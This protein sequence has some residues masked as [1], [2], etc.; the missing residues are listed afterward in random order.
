MNFEHYNRVVASIY[1]A[2]TD[3]AHW[4][5]ALKDVSHYFS[6]QGAG[7]FIQN[8]QVNYV[9]PLSFLGLNDG[10]LA[11][12]SDYYGDINPTFAEYEELRAGTMFTEQVF[13]Q[14][15]Q[16]S[17]YYNNT[18]FY[19]EW[20][21]PQG[22]AHAA[23]GML[24]VENNEMLHFTLL[25]SAEQG[26]YSQ[27][28]LTLL[29][30]FSQHILS[31]VKYSKVFEQLNYRMM[32]A[33]HMLGCLGQ[34]LV[35]LGQDLQVLDLNQAAANQIENNLLLCIRKGKLRSTNM[36]FNKQLAKQSQQIIT[37]GSLNIEIPI[38]LDLPTYQQLLLLLMPAPPTVQTYF[39]RPVIILIIQDNQ[40]SE[41]LNMHYLQCSYHLTAS[42]TRLMSYLLD[43]CE[44]KRAAIACGVTYETARWYL[45][46]IFEKTGTHRQVD[47][48]MKVNADPA[49]RY[50][51]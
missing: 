24:T 41:P 32:S 13:N 36:S 23:G 37:N 15:H 5:Q 8:P 38:R 9:A 30:E 3:T 1:Q 26:Q 27:H 10:F 25:R 42:E 19:N 34:G 35:V 12:Y 16:D 4:D 33:E 14:R 46:S 11:S 39:N 31:A 6:S 2:S 51:R 44:L 7:L 43:G 29:K 28:E 47:L 48:I 20:M 50:T 22:F 18:T 40:S 21:Q 45:K 17:E 49:A